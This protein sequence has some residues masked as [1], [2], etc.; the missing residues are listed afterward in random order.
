LSSGQGHPVQSSPNQYAIMPE[1]DILLINIENIVNQLNYI[2]DQIQQVIATG[3]Q[4]YSAQNLQNST[5]SNVLIKKYQELQQERQAIES[6]MKH[7]NTLDETQTISSLNV[8]QNYYSFLLLM[9]L[10]I[11]IIIVLVYLSRNTFMAS[12]NESTT[13]IN[14]KS[15]VETGGELGSNAFIVIIVI[16]LLIPICY[17]FMPI[18]YSISQINTKS[19]IIDESNNVS[20]FFGQLM[21][22]LRGQS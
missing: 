2:N 10:A 18:I 5:A 4:E 16:I 7:Y 14:I 19:F 8:S 13:T 17:F 9:F 11:V 20:G 21:N 1:T 6:N 22:K 3:Q 12:K 15:N